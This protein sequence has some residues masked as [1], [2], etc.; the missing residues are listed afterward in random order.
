M[1]TKAKLD[2]NAVMAGAEEDDGAG[3]C[4][5]CGAEAYGV[6]PDARKYECEECGKSK[7]YGAMEILLMVGY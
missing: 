2:I 5:G 7:V 4:L 6:E 3:F 1:A